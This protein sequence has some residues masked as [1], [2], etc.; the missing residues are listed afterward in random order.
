MGS[1]RRAQTWDEVAIAALGIDFG[2]RRRVMVVI[3]HR[4]LSEPLNVGYLIVAPR[5]VLETAG[6]PIVIRRRG[7]T[8][9][10]TVNGPAVA[11]STTVTP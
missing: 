9:G 10:I 7:W 1:K 6:Y 5:S 3:G 11:R 4:R 8:R 2:R